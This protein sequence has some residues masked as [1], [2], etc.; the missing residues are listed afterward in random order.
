MLNTGVI[1]PNDHQTYSISASFLPHIECIRVRKTWY[2]KYCLQQGMNKIG[3]LPTGSGDG[4][5][6]DELLKSWALD[7]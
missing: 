1:F 6:K 2:I 4:S 5:R 3:M 7:I